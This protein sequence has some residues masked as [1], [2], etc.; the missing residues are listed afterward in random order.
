MNELLS[1]AGTLDAFYAAI[2]SG[3]NAIYLGLDKFSARAYA[4]NFTLENLKELVKYAHLRNVRI[5][6]T[7]NTL[8]YDDELN[9]V[10]SIIDQLADIHVD[11]LIVQ[12][13]ALLNYITNHYKS[14]EAHASTQMGIDDL[15][16][17]TLIKNLGATRI[18]FAR[19][20]P[21]SVMK[22][23]KEKLGIEI[24]AFI[25]GALCVAYSGNCLMSS[26]IGDRS[27]N[28]G[29]CAGCCRQFYS[30][31]DTDTNSKIESGY[32]LSM[33]DLNASQEINEMN[34]VDSLKIEGRMKEPAYVASVTNYYRNVLDNKKIDKE[35]LDKVFNRTYTKGFMNGTTSE[36]I[37]NIERPN[38]FGYPIGKVVKINKTNVWIK[39]FK[40]LNKGDQIRIES[41][42]KYEE[43]SVPITKLLDP[44]FNPIESSHKTVIITCDKKINLGAIVYKTKD[45]K[46]LNSINQSLLNNDYKKVNIC[47]A[48]A[49]HVGKTMHL[50]VNCGDFS[51]SVE[52]N[53]IVEKS[54][55]RP[56]TKE[57]IIK[58]LSKL[59]ESPYTLSKVDFDVDDNIFISLKE[60][61]E[62]KREAIEKIN[63]IRLK[64]NVITNNYQNIIPK[65]YEL[66]APQIT[67]Q[68]FNEEQYETVKKLG[69]KNIYYK[70]IVRRNNEI[71][72]DFLNQE[73][74][75]GGYGAINHYKDTNN[76]LVADYSLN[77]TNYISCAVLSSLGVDRI[78]LSQEINRD[79]IRQLIKDY[80]EAYNTYPNLE[81]I[82]YGKTTLMHS[83]YCVLKRLNMCGECKKRNFGLKDKFETF[84]LQFNND[85]TMNVL[86]SKA[87]NILDDISS[88]VGINYYRFVFTTESPKE[89]EELI[90]DFRNKLDN[91][92]SK[93]LF[94]SNKNARG[95][96]FKNP[97]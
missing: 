62:L 67:V 56:T 97:L 16:G 23:V 25:H 77:V 40:E 61:N 69:I 44:N 36:N 64:D 2:K 94:D 35:I 60:I 47:M 24:E 63:I 51:A 84:P 71:Y 31:I 46:F 6:V 28:R 27:G 15:D 93:K 54:I 21:L 87:L 76:I 49:G 3:A 29:R 72:K 10:F 95:H 68:V 38:N 80:Y 41:P 96:F 1:P 18:V 5:F 14:I 13:L 91:K 42:K 86:N 89:I 17:A 53:Y 74:L 57:N 88:L 58:Q 66:H 82:V 65:K 45:T 22:S 81:L 8:V 20:T 32:L 52:S 79:N 7:M 75:V 4:T 12:D 85:C 26:M 9:E 37:T 33:K 55:S 30:L 73:I 43:I 19:E 34:F 83:K 70:N 90:N 39:L 92:D 48:F 78:T 59:S 50:N 11:A